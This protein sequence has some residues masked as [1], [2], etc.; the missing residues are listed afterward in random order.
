MET[1]FTILIFL[2]ISAFIKTFIN[3]INSYKNQTYK[4]PPGPS[5]LPIISKFLL[6]IKSLVELETI[7]RTLHSKYGPLITLH[8]GSR[9]AIIIADRFP[10]HQALI[11]NSAVFANRPPATAI[12]KIT[13]SKQHN[14]NTA[15]YGPT[16]R[17]L[18][19]NL[20]SEILSP[21]PVRSYWR[22]RKWVLQI[23]L[24]RL[25]SELANAKNGDDHATA[26]GVFD[27]FLFVMFSLLVLMCFGDKLDEKKIIEVEDVQ[28]LMVLN[29]KRFN[30]LNFC[31][32]VTK[33]VFRKLWEEFCQIRK[34]QDNVLMPLIRERRKLT[35]ERLSF[36]AKEDDDD[37]DYEKRQLDDN[38]IMSLCSEFLDGGTAT[39][40]TSLQWVMANLVKRHPPFHFLSG[41]AVTDDIVFNGFLVPKIATL[42][43]MLVDIGGDPRVWDD[44]M[45][46][47]PERFL[48]CEQNGEEMV[49]DITGS[50]G[51]KIMPFGVGRRICPGLGLPMLH[52][53]Y[54]IANLIWCFEW[55]AVDGGEVDLSERHEFTVV[56][57]NPLKAHVCPR[58]R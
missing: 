12:A 5:K 23:L 21:P 13:S 42:R 4:L 16:W 15:A 35:E 10:I 8:I 51:I 1:C 14:I 45:A 32:R 40:T 54:F 49:F 44:P 56:M 37:D 6:V 11:Q 31:P 17:F 46:F 25:N 34:Q 30:V 41:H 38:E 19:R 43:F 7:I 55:K 9:P 58:V 28:R 2:C 50:R 52:L 29:L 36:H 24:D 33:I 53:E 48:N 22:A 18:R 47:K 39:T 3:L 27:H 20:T 57:K 26:V